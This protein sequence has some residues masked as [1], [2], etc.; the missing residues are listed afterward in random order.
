MNWH[1]SNAK[2]EDKPI[3]VLLIVDGVKEG[4]LVSDTYGRV[5]NAFRHAG[6]EV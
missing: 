1:R 4:I 3:G 2:P 6:M 5:L